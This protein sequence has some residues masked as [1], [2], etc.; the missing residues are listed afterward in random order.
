MAT[1]PTHGVHLWQPHLNRWLMLAIVV[2]AALVGAGAWAL[3]NHYTGGT[4]ETT[5]AAATGTSSDVANKY[6][7][8]LDKL[9]PS[10]LQPILAKNV[11]SIDWAYG[12]G[13]PFR[14]AE[15]LERV[16]S[17]VFASSGD[18][19][20]RGSLRSAGPDWAAVTWRLRGSTNPVTST[21]FTMNGLSILNIKNGRI[22][23][24]TYYWDVPGRNPG[25]AATIGRKFATALS[26]HRQGWGLT[27]RSL[28][29]KDAIESDVGV[30][31]PPAS[32]VN[33]LVW[34][35]WAMPSFMPLHASLCCAGPSYRMDN[36]KTR[37]SWAVV[38]WVAQDASPGG[39]KV[40]GV[41]ILQLK[42]GKIIRETMYH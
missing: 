26:A 34:G 23:R 39:G 15:T 30:A 9:D 8:A 17:G 6:I 31:P 13:P 35:R 1:Y 19:H 14:S 4:T 40:S 3:V 22:I 5:T 29:S 10:A 38:N 2:V 18:A 42:N 27:L 37:L 33:N 32:H 28:Y 11:V 16:W 12:S 24:E 25:I 20:F 7:A 21:P 41:S 36:G